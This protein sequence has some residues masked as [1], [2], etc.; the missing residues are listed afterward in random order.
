MTEKFTNRALQKERLQ[1]KNQ[2]EGNH[3]KQK[4]DLK[5]Q[6]LKMYKLELEKNTSTEQANILLA[7]IARAESAIAKLKNQ[8]KIRGFTEKRGRPK[9][10]VGSTYKEQR[11]KF[12]AHL[13]LDTYEYLQQLKKQR[14]INNISA[15]LDE[16]VTNY[17]KKNSE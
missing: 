9:K 11:K 6:E 14:T 13:Q 12:T 16:L 4:S 7:R 2:L 17:Q 1:K 3:F 15:F 5:K 8:L 10:E